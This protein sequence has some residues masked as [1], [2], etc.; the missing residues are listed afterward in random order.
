MKSPIAKRCERLQKRLILRGCSVPRGST[1]TEKLRRIA[2]IYVPNY[3]RFTH[4]LMAIRA[5]NRLFALSLLALVHNASD[6]RRLE[7][8]A[9]GHYEGHRGSVERMKAFEAR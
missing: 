3:T 6:G 8:G 2:T 4:G 5:G 1:N 9:Q 7:A